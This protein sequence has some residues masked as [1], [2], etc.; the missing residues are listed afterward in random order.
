[1]HLLEKKALVLRRVEED[2][3]VIDSMS[4]HLRAPSGPLHAAAATHLEQT[5]RTLLLEFER[6]LVQSVSE[7]TD[8]ATYNREAALL[9]RALKLLR[10]EELVYERVRTR[11][12]EPVLAEL[13][14]LAL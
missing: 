12:V 4:S 2:L 9:L 11:V 7:E 3:R 13:L 6:I 14:A 5:T 10:K 1:M 8:F